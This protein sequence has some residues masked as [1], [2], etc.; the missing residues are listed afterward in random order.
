MH[1]LKQTSIEDILELQSEIL[2]S[3]QDSIN[4]SFNFT[5]DTNPTFNEDLFGNTTTT[6]DGSTLA[7]DV[8]LSQEELEQLEQ[9]ANELLASIDFEAIFNQVSAILLSDEFLTALD[10][11]LDILYEEMENMGPDLQEWYDLHW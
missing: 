7:A 11:S 3:F 5:V 9:M 10:E 6:F 2:D 8:E 4:T 1:F